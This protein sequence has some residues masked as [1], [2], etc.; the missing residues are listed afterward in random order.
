MCSHQHGNIY[1]A[2]LDQR[3]DLCDVFLM[4]YYTQLLLNI[5]AIFSNRTYFPEMTRKFL[6]SKL[7]NRINRKQKGPGFREKVYV[8]C[9]NS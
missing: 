7:E 1:V 2:L 6:P 8:Y 5:M 4:K 9:L 3:F